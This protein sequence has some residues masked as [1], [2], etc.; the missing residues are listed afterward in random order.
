MQMFFIIALFK[1]TLDFFSKLNLIK[2][3]FGKD[4]CISQY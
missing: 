1:Q 2:M 3:L 4:Y